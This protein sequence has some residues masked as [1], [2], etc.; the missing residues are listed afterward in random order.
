MVIFSGCSTL[1]PVTNSNS[2]EQQSIYSNETLGIQF[3]YPSEWGGI[4]E[5]AE[6]VCLD[7]QIDEQKDPCQHISLKFKDLGDSVLFLS[8]S[9][10]LYSEDIM[11][12]GGYWGDDAGLIEDENY[13]KKYCDDKKDD[14]KIYQNTNGIWVSKSQEYYVPIDKDITIYN[15]KSNN[16]IFYGITASSERLENLDIEN[17]QEKFDLIIDS[18]NFI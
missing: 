5:I 11:G 2:D 15:I 18:L 10:V 8:S 16:P 13:I 12:R 6:Q 7:M 14:C 1:E 17:M 3:E 4:D 9:S